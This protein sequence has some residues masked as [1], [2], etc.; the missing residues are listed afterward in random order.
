MRYGKPV[1]AAADGAVRQVIEGAQCG[2]C[3][4]PQDP[5]AFSE[6]VLEASRSGSGFAEAGNRGIEA[7][8]QM[9]DLDRIV[10]AYIRV[11]EGALDESLGMTHVASPPVS[12]QRRLLILSSRPPFERDSGFKVRVF[13]A[14]VQL[15]RAGW[16][17]DIVAIADHLEQHFSE[18]QLGGACDQLFL[19]DPGRGRFRL[20]LLRGILS[21]LPMQVWY[22][23]FPV[24]MRWVRAHA[25]DYQVVLLNHARMAQYGLEAGP[26]RILDLHDSIG[27]NYA[28]ERAVATGLIR[29]LAYALEGRR[30]SRYEARICS[31]FPRVFVTSAVDRDYIEQH[32]ASPG[33]IEVLPV[34]VR[35]EA[36]DHADQG[37][38]ESPTCCFIGRMGYAPNVAAVRFFALEVLPLIWKEVPA[39]TFDIVGADPSPAVLSLQQIPGVR[40]TG[41]VPDPYPLV[42]R[43]WVFVAPMVSGSGVQNKILEALVLRRA[44]VTTRLGAMGIP[45]LENGVNALILDSPQRFAEATVRLLRDSILRQRLGQAGRDLVL[46]RYSWETIGRRLI[47]AVDEVANG[48]DSPNPNPNLVQPADDSRI[49]DGADASQGDCQ[50]D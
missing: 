21:T 7:A 2:W 36:L 50:E 46:M 25:C 4:A 48:S 29:R 1:L 37:E 45:E 31:G 26:P 13:N 11:L 17:V 34:A 23:R 14:G 5:E 19:Y 15:R 18:D 42:G 44:V 24:L 27:L 10:H 12:G 16:S 41:H 39:V 28:R 8:R 30:M 35:P 43:C 22:Y 47:A 32:G 3:V 49:V 33:T 20:N 38:S 9:F 6:A 40:V